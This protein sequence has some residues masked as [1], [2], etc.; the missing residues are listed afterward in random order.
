VY[1]FLISIVALIVGYFIYGKIVERIFGVDEQ[2]AT[3]AVTMADGVDYVPIEWKS[4]FLIQLLNIAGL[5]PIFGAISGALWG[6]AALLWIVFGCIFAGAVHDFFSGMLSVRH[7]G[8]SVSEIVGH[9]LGGGAKQVMR[10]FSVVLLILVGT[11]FMTGPANLLAALT[12][13]TLT[14]KVW[15][16]AIVTRLSVSFIR[17]SVSCC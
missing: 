16:A 3:P 13:A 8:A 6:P 11:V 7:G 14:A 1:T 12:P 15:L 2:R 10:V 5:G 4:M 9:Y 17:Y